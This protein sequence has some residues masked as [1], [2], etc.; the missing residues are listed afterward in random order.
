MIDAKIRDMPFD[1]KIKLLPY[2][3]KLYLCG[4]IDKALY[5][6]LKKISDKVTLEKVVDKKSC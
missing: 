5:T 3:D 6:Y 4:Y 2:E 1:E